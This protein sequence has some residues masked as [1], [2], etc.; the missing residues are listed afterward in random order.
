M[1]GDRVTVSLDSDASAA[2][3]TLTSRT[4]SGQSALVRRALTFYAANFEAATADASANLEEYH[5]MLAG[6]EHV[7]LDVDFLHC[8]LEHV[9]D[10]SGV[11]DPDFLECADRV[12]EYHTS[13]YDERFSALGELL[14]WLSFCGFLTVRRTEA[15]TYHVVFPTESM[16]W[17]MLRFIERSIAALD[18]E[19]DV[20]EGVS[21]ALFTERRE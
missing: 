1:T 8:F 7:L 14:D 12:A 11:P 6:G 4:E 15:D 21:K 16:K 3:E 19:I 20:D 5:R 9:E 13:E 17:F 10:E 18:F 2:L